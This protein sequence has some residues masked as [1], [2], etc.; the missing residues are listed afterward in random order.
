MA[1]QGSQSSEESAHKPWG[2]RVSASRP[3]AAGSACAPAARRA[4]GSGEPPCIRPAGGEARGIQTDQPG[5]RP[6]P[7]GLVDRLERE[8]L[9]WT[10]HAAGPIGPLHST[11]R[12][13]WQIGYVD[14]ISWLIGHSS[15]LPHPTSSASGRLST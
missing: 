14:V 7:P 12:A 4:S 13:L 11:E 1:P 10:V 9:E 6:V 5:L 2:T 3:S 8:D 15:I